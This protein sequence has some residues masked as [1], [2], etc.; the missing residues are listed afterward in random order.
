[1]R[2]HLAGGSRPLS[3]SPQENQPC[4]GAQLLP[5]KARHW[6]SRAPDNMPGAVPW[7]GGCVL[8]SVRIQ[9]PE[10]AAHQKTT[11]FP[12]SRYGHRTPVWCRGAGTNGCWIKWLP[13]AEHGGKMGAGWGVHREEPFRRKEERVSCLKGRVERQDLQA[14]NTIISHLLSRTGVLES[15]LV[16]WV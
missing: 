8:L 4:L 15:L 6:V 14:R 1:M 7:G 12:E 5:H 16:R 10:L 13:G 3:P 9:S 11:Y 2:S